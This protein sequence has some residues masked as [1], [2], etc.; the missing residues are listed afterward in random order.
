MASLSLSCSS[1]SDGKG[2]HYN[3]TT[4]S[5]GIKQHK[6]NNTLENSLWLKRIIICLGC[7]RRHHLP[8]S[9]SLSIIL[10]FIILTFII[11]VY[12]ILSVIVSVILFIFIVN[13]VIIVTIPMKMKAITVGGNHL[14]GFYVLKG[15]T[16]DCQL[17]G[18]FL[19][20]K[21][22]VSLTTF[23]II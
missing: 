10:I 5:T 14:I 1:S 19:M 15:I 13:F 7:S 4:E 21:L 17:S 8:I 20:S 9:S 3:K 23:I 2:Q 22:T 11:L 6:Y 18:H 12:I 16:G